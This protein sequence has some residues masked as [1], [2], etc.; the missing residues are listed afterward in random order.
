MIDACVDRLPHRVFFSCFFFWRV[1]VAG[2]V[3]L[4]L[5]PP[6]VRLTVLDFGDGGDDA[7]ERDAN[8]V[9]PRDVRACVEV[10]CVCFLLFRL[11]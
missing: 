8:V 5:Q 3:C 4:P 11:R 2:R 7:L 6:A 1:F 10:L 9:R